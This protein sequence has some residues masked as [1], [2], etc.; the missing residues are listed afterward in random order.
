MVD[1]AAATLD[2]SSEIS[3][4]ASASALASANRPELSMV[5]HRNIDQTRRFADV[6]SFSADLV[7]ALM[8][9]NAASIGQGR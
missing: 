7:P 2:I 1:V 5:R 8:R 6:P 9:A 3:I 4:A